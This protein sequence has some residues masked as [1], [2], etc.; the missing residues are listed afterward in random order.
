MDDAPD[1]N[2]RSAHPPCPCGPSQS[3]QGTCWNCEETVNV[4]A[5]SKDHA[6]MTQALFTR[7]ERDFAHRHGVLLDRRYS[8]TVKSRYL[9]NV[10]PKCDHMQGDWFIYFDPYR[11][12]L[13]RQLAQREAHGPCDR[14]STSSCPRHRAYIDYDGANRCPLCLREAETIACSDR[15]DLLCIYPDDCLAG[16]CICPHPGIHRWDGYTC[17]QNDAGTAT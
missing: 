4:G 17:L 2:A 10:C 9:A 5:G 14:C 11:D 13:S 6:P 8:H 3:R 16:T 15:T 1:P 12:V 7:E